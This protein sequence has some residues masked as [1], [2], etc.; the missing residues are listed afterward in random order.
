MVTMQLACLYV[1]FLLLQIQD[2]W[3]KDMLF[4]L[5]NTVKGVCIV[6]NIRLFQC[7]EQLNNI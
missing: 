7:D 3:N 6:D 2:K 5:H 1:H 4:R